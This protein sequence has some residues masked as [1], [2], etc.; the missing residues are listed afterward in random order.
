MGNPVYAM[1]QEVR[2]EGLDGL[3]ELKLCNIF[4]NPRT[5]YT[6]SSILSSLKFIYFL[7]QNFD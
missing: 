7:S 3:A 5:V 1:Y 6:L 2:G 4:V